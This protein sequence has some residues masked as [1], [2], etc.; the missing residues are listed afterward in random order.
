MTQRDELTGLRSRRSLF[1]EIDREVTQAAREDKL[2]QISVMMMDLDF[3]KRVNDG[4]GHLVGSQTIKE[5]GQIIRDAVGSADRAARY[6]GEEYLAYLVGGREEG[7]QVAE[8]LRCRVEAH[9]FSA[10][11]S[12]PSQTMHITISVGV[13]TFPDD[14]TTGLELILRADQA[15]YRAKLTGRNRT[16]LYDPEIDTPDAVQHALDA[17]AIIQGPADA[18]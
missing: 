4:R 11:T 13:A 3:F 5:V 18:Q 9:P 15:L 16:C 6:G 7:L 8:S 2:R 12:D 14:G 17:F 10:S 1:A